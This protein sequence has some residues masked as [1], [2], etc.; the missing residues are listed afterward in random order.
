MAKTAQPLRLKQPAFERPDGDPSDRLVAV[1]AKD[2]AVIRFSV[3]ERDYI[4]IAEEQWIATKYDRTESVGIRRRVR[5]NM[6]IHGKRHVIIVIDEELE[7]STTVPLAALLTQRELQI[8]ELISKGDDNKE[9]AR[10]LGISHFTVREHVRRIF[11]KL[12]LT[13]RSALGA[14]INGFALG[15]S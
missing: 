7:P 1:F 11:H 6:L 4:A 12:K 10:R 13:K 2:P 9:I 5:G 8:A 3:L 14:V 15:S